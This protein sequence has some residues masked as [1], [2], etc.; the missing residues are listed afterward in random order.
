M[1][2]QLRANEPV[3]LYG[4]PALVI[5]LGVFVGVGWLNGEVA[6]FAKG[7]LALLLGIPALEAARANVTPTAKATEAVVEVVTGIKEAVHRVDDA[8]ELNPDGRGQATVNEILHGID[9][10]ADTYTYGRHA[11]QE[12]SAG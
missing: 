10:A 3:R 8:S 2:T 9:V 7:G 5:M 1:L 4:Y 12:T 6:E 11:R